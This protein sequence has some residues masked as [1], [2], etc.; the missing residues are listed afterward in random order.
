MRPVISKEIPAELEKVF[1]TGWIGEGE[2][3]YRFEQELSGFLQA[4]YTVTVNSGTSAI[5]LALELL[6]LQEG[7]SVISTPLT[8][9]ATNIPA[10]KRKIQIQWAD[11]DPANGILSPDSIRANLTPAVKAI[12]TVDLHGV[13]SHYEEIRAIADQHHLAVLADCAQAMGAL[14]NGRQAPAYA[15]ICC[16]SFQSVKTLTTAD[17]GALVFNDQRFLERAVKLRWLGI[18]RRRKLTHLKPWLYDIEEAGHK[19]HMNNVTA[20]MG[21]CNLKYLGELIAHQQTIASAYTR[22]IEW[23]DDIAPFQ[24][25]DMQKPCFWVFPL[26]IRN[27]DDFIFY[28][29]SHGIETTPLHQANTELSAFRDSELVSPSRDGLRGV[30]NVN[31][32]L[33]CLPTGYW[34]DEPKLQ[35]I[36]DTI[37][38]YRR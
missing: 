18:D 27:R 22:Q 36:I 21:L 7:D 28:M 30:C 25:T 13:P 38:H 4:N 19:Y 23:R 3:V 2:W 5:D 9:A 14:C 35:R 1:R 32:R 6:G 20:A 24:Y 26:L 8:C 17:G 34:I 29:R 16:Y 12:I 10:L 11:V 15:D 33:V 37:N 31:E